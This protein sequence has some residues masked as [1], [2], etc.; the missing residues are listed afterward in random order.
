MP[1]RLEWLN[2]KVEKAF[3]EWANKKFG[4]NRRGNYARAFELLVQFMQ[5]NQDNFEAWDKNR[6]K[7]FMDKKL[8]SISPGQ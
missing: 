8:M 3:K 1:L 7:I 5:D 2:P 4:I 6:L